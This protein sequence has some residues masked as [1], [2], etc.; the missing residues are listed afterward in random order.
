MSL[1]NIY[2]FVNSEIPKS[3]VSFNMYQTITDIKKREFPYNIM[4]IQN[5][6]IL[7][8]IAHK[9]YITKND[10]LTHTG[11]SDKILVFLF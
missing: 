10:D 6:K 2:E 5:N 4:P 9:D 1:N 3:V 11:G 8:N 7:P